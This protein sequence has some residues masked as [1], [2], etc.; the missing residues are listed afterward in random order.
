MLPDPEVPPSLSTRVR[1]RTRWCDEDN[2]AVLN[3]AVVMTLFEEGRRAYFDRL[4]LM[5]G[6]RFPFLLAQTNVRYL[7]PGR[8][9][10]EAL[11]ELGTLRLGRSSIEQAYRLRGP[12]GEVWAQARALLVSYDPESGKSRPMSEAFRKAVERHEAQ[13]T[14]QEISL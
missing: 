5:Q 3:N 6:G 10:V 8:G 1:L 7:S 2:Q 9:G 12:E 13:E 14:P 11:L 4:G